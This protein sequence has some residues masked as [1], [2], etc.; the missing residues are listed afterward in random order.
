MMSIVRQFLLGFDK[1][2]KLG[3]EGLKDQARSG[4]PGILSPLEKQLVIELC[5][6]T[7]RSIS[8]IRAT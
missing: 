8:M 3:L 2:E 4:H 1:W 7:P 6:E 5:Q